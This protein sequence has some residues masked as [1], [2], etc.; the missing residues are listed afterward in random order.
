MPLAA[1]PE[2]VEM[3]SSQ[4]DCKRRVASPKLLPD[5]ESLGPMNR[6]G[7]GALAANDRSQWHQATFRIWLRELNKRRKGKRR[8]YPHLLRHSIAVHLLRGGADIRYVQEFL[9][10][11]LLETTKIY[12][13]LVLGHLCE[14]YDEAMPEIAIK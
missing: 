4:C 11:A 1:V 13:R 7:A 10:H 3:G 12:L 6:F 14:E 9:G 2:P 8:I 5:D